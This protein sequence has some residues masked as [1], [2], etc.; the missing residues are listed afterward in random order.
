[1]NSDEQVGL[2]VNEDRELVGIVPN[3]KS[4]SYK[5]MPE[6]QTAF[7]VVDSFFTH[8]PKKIDLWFETPNP[9]LG[10]MSP[11]FMLS[12]GRGAKLLKCMRDWRDGNMP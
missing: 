5:D 4:M 2:L 11:A 1:M 6:Y 8:D 3:E 7:E 9:L 10:G 12:V